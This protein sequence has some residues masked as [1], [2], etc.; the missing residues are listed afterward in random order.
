MSRKD[1]CYRKFLEEVKELGIHPLAM[2]RASF[3]DKGKN[4]LMRTLEKTVNDTDCVLDSQLRGEATAPLALTVGLTMRK[5][6]KKRESGQLLPPPDELVLDVL[7]AELVLLQDTNLRYDFL[8]VHHDGDK[9]WYFLQGSISAGALK[10]TMGLPIEKNVDQKFCKWSS[11]SQLYASETWA[12]GPELREGVEVLIIDDLEW[13]GGEE[14]KVDGAGMI[15]ADLMALLQQELLGA[16]G[17]KPSN[18]TEGAMGSQLHAI[19]SRWGSCKVVLVAM[20]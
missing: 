15:S 10:S 3:A 2:Y 14:S 9:C 13:Y 11:R 7:P 6:A 20:L 17:E 8:D 12:V 5:K 1:R 4:R 18:L 16:S 19:Q